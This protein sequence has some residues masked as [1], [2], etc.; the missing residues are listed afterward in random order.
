MT[1]KKKNKYHLLEEVAPVID[2]LVAGVFDEGGVN[3]V[4]SGLQLMLRH[5]PSVAQH[6]R[7]D[8]EGRSPVPSP[9][10]QHIKV[11]VIT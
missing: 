11:E 6:L 5:S 10:S 7:G 3:S 2:V 4:D 9:V 1:K 8:I